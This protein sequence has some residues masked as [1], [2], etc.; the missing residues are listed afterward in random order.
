MFARARLK[1]LTLVSRKPSNLFVR[2]CNRRI[3][4]NK[5]RSGLR[6][7][8]RKHFVQLFFKK[9][10][11]NFEIRVTLFCLCALIKR[12]AIIFNGIFHLLLPSPTNTQR[13]VRSAAVL[14]ALHFK[15][16]VSLY[17]KLQVLVL[18][19][20]SILADIVTNVFLGIFAL[21]IIQFIRHS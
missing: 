6:L 7:L 9:G 1:P 8:V 21:V 19:L 16:P 15:I 14:R 3:L 20:R 5:K 17:P 12:P 13:K 4:L 10:C 18:K 11:L 2:R